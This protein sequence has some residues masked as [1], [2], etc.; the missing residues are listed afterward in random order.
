MSRSTTPDFIKMLSKLEEFFNQQQR[1]SALA[2]SGVRPL[3]TVGEAGLTRRPRL[4]SKDRE[5][6]HEVD[7]KDK[8]K[9]GKS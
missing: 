9:D 1:N 5:D 8:H 7:G 2:L 3:S 4:Y 6:K